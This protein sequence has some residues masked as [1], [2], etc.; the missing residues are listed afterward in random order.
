MKI[1]I[2]L[3]EVLADEYGNMENLAETIKRQIVDNLTNILK[4]RV[5]V[6]VDKKTSEM[7][8][9]EL[10][11]VV[12]AQMPTLFN[13][14]IDREYTTYDSNGRKGVSTTLRN[15]II[16][17]LTKQMI[18]KNT[19]YNSDKNYFT[20]SVDE[21]VKSRCNEFKLK[22]NKEVDDI[23]VKEALDYAVA[24]LKTRLNV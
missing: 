21:I 1:E 3:G 13:E 12:A 15:A 6:E 24:K 14:L 2:D 8:N 11:K 5:A 19:N 9:A 7:I 16:D 4:S 10:Q 18:Y 22:F 23:F 17:T 20:L